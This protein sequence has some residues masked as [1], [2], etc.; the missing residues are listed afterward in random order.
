MS[1]S[2]VALPLTFLIAICLT[3]TLTTPVEELSATKSRAIDKTKRQAAASTSDNKDYA[4]ALRLSILFYYA[5]RSGKLPSDNPIPWRSDSALSDCVQGGWYDAGDH[6]KFGYPMAGALTMLLWGMDRFKQGYVDANQL[7]SMYDTVKWGL[8]YIVKAWD[9]NTQQLVIQVGGG[10]IDHTFWGRPEDM[11][12]DRPCVKIGPNAPGSDVAGETV[13]AL[14]AGAI[15][16]KDKDPSY[17]ALL[18]RTA[19]SLYSFA[20]THRGKFS[21][22]P[23]V[24]GTFWYY[25]S[26]N[27]K[28]EMCVGAMW[29]YKATQEAQYL[30]DAKANHESTLSDEWSWLDHT[31]A[32]QLMLYEETKEDSYKTEVSN[33]L[34]SWQPGGKRIYTPCGMAWGN[35]TYWGSARHVSNVAFGALVAAED[36]IDATVN[37]KWAAEQIN[38]LLGDNNHDGGCFSY[39]I[40]Y[41]QKYPLRPHH[42]AASC[43]SPPATCSEAVHLHTHEASPHVLYGGLVGGPIANGGYND[44]REDYVH[45]E[46]ALDY[47][48]GFHSALAGLT[49]L[50]AK[51]AIPVTES[52]CP[53]NQAFSGDHSVIIG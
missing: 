22:N 52:K 33:F 25:G 9:P 34:R 20:K 49:E 46:V 5:Q 4:A 18:L 44:S 43:P 40:G 42:R 16:F 28:D 2:V 17:S 21:D 15:V 29:M 37:R 45:N 47:N 31:F 8:D 50:K 27:E 24:T 48:S 26:N 23:T 41:G 19:R 32:C 38:F 7:D 11:T 36:G 6:V 14:A 10:D 35:V 51:Q 53:C 1:R 3:L 30:T 13:A 12:M 39:E